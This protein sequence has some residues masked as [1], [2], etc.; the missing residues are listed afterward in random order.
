MVVA[1]DVPAGT[2]ALHL[3]APY[4]V[5]FDGTVVS[6]LASSLRLD[7]HRDASYPFASADTLI[8]GRVVRASGV[9]LTGF[10]VRLNDPDPIVPHHRVPLNS[11]GEF[12]IFVPEK[13]TS[14]SVTLDVFH[15]GGTLA[16]V[17]PLI[18][19]H[20]STVIPLTTVP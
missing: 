19:V 13:S 15:P 4:Y 17:T 2:Y 9:T 16:V 3:R 18:L 8:R 6:P 14:G 10:D 5:P 11:R 7:L 20:R 12:V 1:P